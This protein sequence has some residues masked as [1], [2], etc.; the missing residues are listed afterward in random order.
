M[1]TVK[2]TAFGTMVVFAA[3]LMFAACKR[4]KTNNVTTTGDEDTYYAEDQARMDQTY[5]DAQNIGDQAY[6]TGSVE[7]KGGDDDNI[8]GGCAV[9]THDTISTPRKITINFGTTNCTCK[10]GRTRRGKIIISYTGKYRDSG[11]VHSIAFDG[12]FVNDNAVLG[13]RTVTNMGKNSNSQTYFNISV[14]G[15]IILTTGDTIS[16]V[17]SRVRTWTAGE[18]TLALSDDEYTITGNGT[19][20]RRSGKVVNYAINTPLV[21][22]LNCRWIK[23]GSIDF[24][25]SGATSVKRTIDFGSGICDDQATVTVGTK[26]KTITLR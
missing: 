7:L 16:H 3:V 22:A 26:T 4:D 11:S 12:Y 6:A 17:A 24:T 20:T 5:D 8:L 1:R 15:M 19:N 18:N 25:P 14:N 23:Q 2:I 10:D 21:V 9:I 13:G